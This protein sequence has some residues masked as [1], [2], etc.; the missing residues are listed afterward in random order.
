MANIDFLGQIITVKLANKKPCSLT[1]TAHSQL[2]LVSSKIFLKLFAVLGK[3]KSFQLFL[4]IN[5]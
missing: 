2:D 1:N 3:V 4:C 5:A